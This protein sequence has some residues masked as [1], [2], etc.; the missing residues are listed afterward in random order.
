MRRDYCRVPSG[1]D[2]R[3]WHFTGSPE[4]RLRSSRRLAVVESLSDPKLDSLSL[5]GKSNDS[6]ADP[7]RSL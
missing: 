1:Q 5:L 4:F 7:F 3:Y 2:L 6:W